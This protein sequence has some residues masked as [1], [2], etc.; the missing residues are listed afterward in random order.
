MSNKTQLQTNNTNLQTVLSNVLGLPTEE[1]CKNGAY[2]WKKSIYI[3]N[4]DITINVLTT[5]APSTMKAVSSDYDL[6]QVD[7]SFFVGYVGILNDNG[8]N[9]RLTFKDGGVL[10]TEWGTNFSSSSNNTY[11]Y[12]PST[13]VITISSAW[14]TTPSGTFSKDDETEF[15][16]FVVSDISTAYPDG[17]TQDGYW[18]EKFKIDVVS[19]SVN[20]YIGEVY[21][22]F[23][24]TVAHGLGRKP[25]Y[26]GITSAIPGDSN[27]LYK[28]SIS[29]DDT[30]IIFDLRYYSPYRDATFEWFAITVN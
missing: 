14:S 10:L 9:T 5:S 6:S 25:D 21:G 18:Y 17:G 19:D 30:N 8:T 20:F 15:I 22:E 24:K 11:S 4:K 12:N 3:D 16:E 23:Q 26:Y 27:I 13:Q 7:E 28:V 2:V 1:S 29:A